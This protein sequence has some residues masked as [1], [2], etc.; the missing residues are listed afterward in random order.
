M[1]EVAFSGTKN[2]LR[3]RVRAALGGINESALDDAVIDE[4]ADGNVTP[5]IAS[6][7]HKPEQYEQK[8]VDDAIVYFTAYRAFV[9]VPLKSTISGGGLTAN[10]APEQYRKE[11]R[12]RA[13][14]SLAKLDVSLPEADRPAAFVKSSDGMFSGKW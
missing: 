12:Q 5:H 4:N 7:I 9:S 3:D 14:Q 13:S 2:E 10:M 6:E 8:Q 1:A 11:L